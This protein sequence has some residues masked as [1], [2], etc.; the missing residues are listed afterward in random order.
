MP[1]KGEHLRLS[2]LPAV[3]GL[4][5]ADYSLFS[6]P[7]RALTL[8]A[9]PLRYTWLLRSLSALFFSKPPAAFHSFPVALAAAVTPVD[10]R[11]HAC[12]MLTEESAQCFP[13]L[14]P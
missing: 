7:S 12:G 1:G 10:H 14:G 5:W 4:P 2:E 9:A 3:Q 8:V 13:T 6:S 11:R